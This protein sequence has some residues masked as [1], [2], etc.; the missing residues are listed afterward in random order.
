MNAFLRGGS[1]A[2]SSSYVD[3]SYITMDMSANYKAT[4]NL[5]FYAK[6]Y[7]LFNKAYAESAG[8]TGGGSYTYPAQGF[9]FLIGAEF[10]F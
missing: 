8:V 7:N 10:S 6:G 1:G 4:D 2:D 5:S 3:S 9:H